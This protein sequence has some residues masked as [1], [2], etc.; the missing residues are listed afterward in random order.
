MVFAQIL[1]GVIVNTIVLN[2]P[3]LLGLFSQSYDSVLQVDATYPQPGI[4]WT[5]DGIQFSPPPQSTSQDDG[6][7]P[8]EESVTSNN[9]IT[10]PLS[11]DALMPN[12]TLTPG[13]GQYIAWFNCIVASSTANASVSVS[14]YING[15]QLAG[16][17]QT[18]VPYNGGLLAT[19]PGNATISI[20]QPVSLADGDRIEIWW[21]SSNAGAT[22]SSRT[23]TI[24]GL[25]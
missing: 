20:N 19:P 2:D 9:S 25:S 18:V 3:S 8:L 12:M 10:A 6:S 17:L 11:V 5:F 24:I 1:N 7:P 14:I 23:L 13:A 22:T 16:S 4:G 15:V 21:S